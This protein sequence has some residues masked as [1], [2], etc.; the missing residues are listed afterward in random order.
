M[1]SLSADTPEALMRAR[2]AAFAR[3]DFAFL[4][5]TSTDST[6]LDEVSRAWLEGLKWCRLEVIRAEGSQVEFKAYYV[7]GGAAQCLHEVSDFVQNE[8]GEW[9]YAS[10][11][12]VRIPLHTGRNDACICGSGKKFKKC[13]GA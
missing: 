2:Y 6:P 10:G 11:Q 8:A 1:M 3:K 4:D 13:C 7:D 5:A 12:V 9:R